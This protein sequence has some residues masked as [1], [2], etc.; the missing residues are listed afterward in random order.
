MFL[1]KYR[2]RGF[3]RT[4]NVLFDLNMEVNAC[5]TTCKV[6]QYDVCISGEHIDTSDQTPPGAWEIHVTVPALFEDGKH[7]T[8]VPHTASVKVFDADSDHFEHCSH[9]INWH[10]QVY[11]LNSTKT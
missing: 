4:K 7:I 11:C 8:E 2:E 1:R 3:K 5:I 9:D 6:Q 10:Y